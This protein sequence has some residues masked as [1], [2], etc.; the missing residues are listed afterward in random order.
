VFNDLSTRQQHKAFFCR[1]QLDD[2]R[3]GKFIGNS[4]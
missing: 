2:S 1:R 4:R 3:E